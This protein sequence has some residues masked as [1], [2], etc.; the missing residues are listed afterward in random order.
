[1]I[2]YVKGDATRPVGDGDKIIC[3]ICNNIGAWGAG[4]VLALSARWKEPERHYREWY[5]RENTLKLGDVQFI[6]VEDDVIVTNMI[7]QDNLLTSSNTIPVQ[8]DAVEMCLRQV[9]YIAK[10]QGASVHMPR[11]GCGLGGGEWSRIEDIVQRTLLEDDVPVTVY[12]L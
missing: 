8:Y 4:F 11:I 6:Q 10:K 3:H 5:A 7:A 12:D 1:M 2:K 9:A